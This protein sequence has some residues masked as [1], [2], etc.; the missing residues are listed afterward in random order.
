MTPAERRKRISEL[1]ALIEG[2]V[3]T[4]RYIRSN[5]ENPA[6]VRDEIAHIKANIEK[7]QRDVD[8]LET[9]L[10]TGADDYASNR[11]KILTLRTEI[12]TLKH[13]EKLSELA[14]L[15]TKLSELDPE[16][17]SMLLANLSNPS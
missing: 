5:L 6:R 10:V 13:E 3:T 15:Q 9:S 12:N 16:T 17:R 11:A 2:Y 4:N 7:F 14:D 1:E 8:R